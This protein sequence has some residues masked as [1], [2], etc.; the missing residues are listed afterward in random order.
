[1]VVILKIGEETKGKESSKKEKDC[2]I[3]TKQKAK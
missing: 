3:K 1:L 2:S